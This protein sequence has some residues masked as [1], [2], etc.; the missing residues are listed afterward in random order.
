MIPVLLVST[1]MLSR[2]HI[3]LVLTFCDDD[4]DDGDDDGGG[5]GGNSD[6]SDDGNDDDDDGTKISSLVFH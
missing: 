2:R 1:L 6:D 4:Y 3:G 5:G